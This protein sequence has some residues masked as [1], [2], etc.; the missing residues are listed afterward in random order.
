[1]GRRQERSDVRATTENQTATTG[2]ADRRDTKWPVLAIAALAVAAIVVGFAFLAGDDGDAPPGL[3]EDRALAF[4]D[5]YFTTHNA[6]D[7][8]A[9]FALFTDDAVFD[10]TYDVS[11]EE[12]IPDEA[13]GGID[14]AG[15]EPR[16]AWDLAQGERLS[17]PDC[18]ILDD[19]AGTAVTLRC[20]Y[21]TRDAPGSAIDATEIPTIADIELT[22]DGISELREYYGQPDFVDTGRPF[23]AWL[24]EHHPEVADIAGCCSGET[25]EES[26]TRGELRAEY[27]A[28]WAADLAGGG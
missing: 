10:D 22:P 9:T 24:R 20:R 2:R 12:Q 27:A 8:D 23:D 15:W 21:G 26:I 13:E 25:V 5:E 19:V 7:I 3:T 6:G 4:V 28:R 18:T 17:T 14:R 16:F 1:M 11:S